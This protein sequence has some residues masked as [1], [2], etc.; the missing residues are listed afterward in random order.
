MEARDLELQTEVGLNFFRHHSLPSQD[1]LVIVQAVELIFDDLENEASRC[2]KI[3]E[4]KEILK[5]SDSPLPLNLSLMCALFY[6]AG[7]VPV[8]CEYAGLGV[9]FDMGLQPNDKTS[10]T[11]ILKDVFVAGWAEVQSFVL[12]HNIQHQ[13]LFDTTTDL[14]VD[15]IAPNGNQ[16]AP[17][18]KFPGGT[19]FC[20][21]W[22]IYNGEVLVALQGKWGPQHRM[23]A[24]A[25]KK[26]F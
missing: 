22:D 14:F 26:G 12:M 17:D 16:L 11:V 13:V 6:K 24:G 19:I 1:P 23:L 5:S 7:L 21:M 15:L 10:H 18:A 3:L 20:T 9:D 8:F 2:T 4:S 25:A